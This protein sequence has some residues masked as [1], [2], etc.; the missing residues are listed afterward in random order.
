M[1]LPLLLLALAVLCVGAG[2]ATAWPLLE[3]L[4]YSLGALLLL[5]A[6][7]TWAATKHLEIDRDPLPP[8]VMA[9]EILPI[10]Y[11]LRK[12]G[13]LPG[14]QLF[15]EDAETGQQ[16]RVGL[17][18]LGE[19]TVTLDRYMDR[20]G[21]YSI[22]AAD[23]Y[24]EDP[25]GIFRRRG[26]SLGSETITVYPRPIPV[27]MIPLPAASTHAT[28]H[29]WRL[30]DADGTLGHLR[31]YQPG[32]PPSRVHWPST[33]RAGALMVADPE[34]HRPLTVW[35]LVDLSGKLLPEHS[36]GIAA[37]LAQEII[38]LGLRLGT[39]I[40][41]RETVSIQPNRG[42]RQK[43]AVLDALATVAACRQSQLEH[44]I[45]LASRIDRPGKLLVISP[46]PLT[47]DQSRSLRRLCPDVTHVA[48]TSFAEAFT[49]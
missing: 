15:L 1:R 17:R 24:A 28:R 26:A 10:S 40:A 5:A 12:T 18:G 44:L 33:A 29:R 22:G 34:T 47:P 45:R 42:N 13:I 4:G 27:P 30:A 43:L 7:V 14:L 3:H 36:A 8:A 19:Q 2:A 6:T 11:R 9:G 16:R 35:L 41:G 23:V 32:D 20:R 31:P 37:Y 49:G 38:E 25:L 21:R 39:V 46:A 48:A